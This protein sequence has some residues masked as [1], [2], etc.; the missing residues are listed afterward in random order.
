MII[1]LSIYY[2]HCLA[3]EENLNALGSTFTF[4]YTFSNPSMG[5]INGTERAMVLVNN[6]KAVS[7]LNLRNGK[8]IDINNT[9]FSVNTILSIINGAKTDK[10][11]IYND[12]QMPISI[13]NTCPKDLVGC[14]YTIE[15]EDYTKIIDLNYQIDSLT[16]R[17]KEFN[18]NYNKW[19]KLNI[20]NYQFTYQ[21]N[22]DMD[23]N[24]EG[25]QVKIKNNKVVSAK[26]MRSYNDI[27]IPVN[28]KF[29]T[30]AGLFNIIERRMKKGYQVEIDYNKRY[31]YPSFVVINLYLVP[32]FYSPF[33]NSK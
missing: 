24:M 5:P 31:G 6:K 30:I 23:T 8:F 16:Q 25:L 14:G 22:R 17:L 29:M 18:R 12:N 11:V 21:D 20:L 4:Q 19:K 1:L 27:E 3:A 13:S 7:V 15:I 10:N 26:D 32:F 33:Y 9:S 28:R 2:T